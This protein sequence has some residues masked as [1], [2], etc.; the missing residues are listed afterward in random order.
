MHPAIRS[1]K[2]HINQY[3]ITP[4]ILNWDFASDRDLIIAEVPLASLLS[5]CWR[6]SGFYASEFLAVT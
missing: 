1:G 5:R 3:V 2:G 6:T 4:S